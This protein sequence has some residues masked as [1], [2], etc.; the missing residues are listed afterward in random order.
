VI[1]VQGGALFAHGTK[2]LS[3]LQVRRLTLGVFFRYAA[4][5]RFYIWLVNDLHLLFKNREIF[6][7]GILQIRTRNS[8]AQPIAKADIEEP[9]SE[10][11][12]HL[13]VP[14]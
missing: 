11:E 1:V 12:R 13:N 14:H 4:S 6:D 8:G 5:F 9:I 2:L 10:P 3:H 7:I